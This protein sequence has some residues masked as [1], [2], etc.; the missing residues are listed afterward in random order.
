MV[1]L[2]FDNKPQKFRTGR[3]LRGHLIRL[4]QL[5]I[6]IPHWVWGDS[7]TAIGNIQRAIKHRIGIKWEVKKADIDM[8][9]CHHRSN[10]WSQ[11]HGWTPEEKQKNAGLR[12]GVWIW[13]RNQEVRWAEEEAIRSQDKSQHNIL[14]TKKKKLWQRTVAQYKYTGLLLVS[15][16]SC[17]LSPPLVITYLPRALLGTA[18]PTFSLLAATKV[19]PS[20]FPHTFSPFPGL[21]TSSLLLPLHTL[22][23]I[24]VNKHPHPFLCRVES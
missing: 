9:V 14:R 21:H 2:S 6:S 17:I 3:D 5:D 23:D 4:I 15:L 13:K 12:T 24:A 20:V 8:G 19:L 11:E 16:G 10:N 7:G 22:T 18:W 1:S